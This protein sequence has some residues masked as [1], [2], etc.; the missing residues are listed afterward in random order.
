MKPLEIQFSAAIIPLTLTRTSPMIF[1]KNIVLPASAG[2]NFD[3]PD[4]S[5]Q[6]ELLKYAF[7]RIAAIFNSQYQPP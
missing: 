5:I 7:Q 4:I 3:S 2:C 6:F 1:Y